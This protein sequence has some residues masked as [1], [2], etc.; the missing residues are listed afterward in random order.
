MKKKSKFFYKASASINPFN[1]EIL[2]MLSALVW[3]MYYKTLFTSLI[4]INGWLPLQ[5][6]H[7]MI[8]IKFWL[9]LEPGSTL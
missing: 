7:Y 1:G 9:C 6:L 5:L 2:L 3:N 4:N 8:H